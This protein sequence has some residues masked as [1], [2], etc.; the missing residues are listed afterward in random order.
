MGDSIDPF[1]IPLDVDVVAG[2]GDGNWV[3]PPAGWARFRGKPQLSIVVNAG[4]QGD[5]LD[6]EKGDASPADLPG[7]C[8]RFQR[9]G[10]RAPT[11]YCNRDSWPACRAAVGARRVDWW[12]STLDGTQDVPGAVAVQYAGSAM[13]GGHY[14]LSVILDPSWI[15]GTMSDQQIQADVREELDRGTA[16]GETSWA[17]TMQDTLGTIQSVYNLSNESLADIQRLVLNA[18]GVTPAQLG[19]ALRAAAHV[20]DG[21]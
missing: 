17:K 8:D 7:W 3:W 19:E 4:D 9:P 6:V 16:I 20:L 21:L 13:T 15:G 18:T 10:R 11:G 2:Y 12:I 1:A 14:D 5:V